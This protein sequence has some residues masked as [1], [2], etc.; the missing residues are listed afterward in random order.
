MTEFRLY[1]N[2]ATTKQR[3][4]LR[5]GAGLLT[6]ILVLAGFRSLRFGQDAWRDMVFQLLIMAAVF[7]LFLG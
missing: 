6:A 1:Q 7:A 4:N 2:F 3:R 5:A